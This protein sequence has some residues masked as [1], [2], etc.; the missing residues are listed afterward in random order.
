MTAHHEQILDIILDKNE[1]TWQTILYDLVNSEQMDPWNIDVSLLTKKY[2]EM[3]KTLKQHDFRVSG[4]VVLA[5]AILLKIKSTRWIQ[6]DIANLDALFNASEEQDMLLDG[7]DD[8]IPSESIDAQ[9]IPRTPQ[10]RKR[11]VSIF[12]LVN[13]LER[14]LDVKHRRVL[15]DIPIYDVKIPQKKRDISLIIRELYGQIRQFFQKSHHL[16]FNRLLPSGSRE[17][18][19]YTFIPLLHLTNQ[20]KICLQQAQPFGEIEIFLKKE[21]E[22]ELPEPA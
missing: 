12:D 20:H 8:R 22:K 5:A 6:E 15:R 10:P 9:L 3:L 13:A 2:I 19:I 17:S 4:K 14:A 16:T 21:V 7:I 18:R 11:K 1:I